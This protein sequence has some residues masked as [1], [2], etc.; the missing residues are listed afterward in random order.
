MKG[1]DANS[2]RELSDNEILSVAG[3]EVLGA[4]PGYTASIPASLFQTPNTVCINLGA[5]GGII[6]YQD[7]A[8]W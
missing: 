6:S 2:V 7:T 3:G 4:I 5:G 1:N 8:G